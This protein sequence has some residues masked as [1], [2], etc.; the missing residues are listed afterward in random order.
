[1]VLGVEG[2]DEPLAVGLE[3]AVDSATRRKGLLGRESLPADSALIIAPS[4][5]VHTFGM[6]FPIDIVFAARDGLVLKIRGNVP[7][8]RIAVAL[9]GFAVVEMSAGSAAQA[10]LRKGDRLVLRPR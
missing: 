9:R 6:R 4:N 2:R 8:S 3:W 5:G 10:G 7:K 1:M